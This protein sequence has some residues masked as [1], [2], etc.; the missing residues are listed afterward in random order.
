MSKSLISVWIHIEEFNFLKSVSP[1]V[2]WTPHPLSDVVRIF[3]CLSQ[4]RGQKEN[5][6]FFL[7]KKRSEPLFWEKKTNF[8]AELLIALTKNCWKNWRPIFRRHVTSFRKR[9]GCTTLT[10][11]PLNNYGTLWPIWRPWSKLRFLPFFLVL[12]IF[13]PIYALKEGKTVNYVLRTIRIHLF[14]M[15]RQKW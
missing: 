10:L 4:K 12:A 1:L 2:R 9:R 5:L 6:F 15:L 8:L 13:A 11:A 7:P 3:F 14:H